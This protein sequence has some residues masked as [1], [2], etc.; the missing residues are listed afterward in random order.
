[1]NDEEN[2][3][4]WTI[5]ADKGYQGSVVFCRI[6][7]PINKRANSNLTN[8]QKQINRNITS[9]RIIVENYFERKVAL[10]GL[11]AHKY[12][13][14]EGD[15]DIFSEFCTALTNLH[16]HKHPLRAHNDSVDRQSY[17]RYN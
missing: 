8:E 13:W 2:Q 17:L 6:I 7:H 5:L 1:M 14:N 4:H 12:R 16:I 10:W 11:M 15:Y 3:Q 9:D